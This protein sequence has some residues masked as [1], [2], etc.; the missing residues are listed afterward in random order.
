LE[1]GIEG[2]GRGLRHRGA[3]GRG[4]RLRCA[5]VVFALA[6]SSSGCYRYSRVEL[7]TVPPAADVRLH[8]TW[9]GLEGR[10]DLVDARIVG[11]DAVPIVRGTLLDRDGSSV[12]LGVRVD[13]ANRDYPGTRIEQHVTIPVDAILDAEMRSLRR[14]ET[15]LVVAGGVAAA[16]LLLVHIVGDAI[17]DESR[18]PELQ[19]WDENRMPLPAD[20][21]QQIE[22]RSLLPVGIP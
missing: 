16:A 21:Y 22:G 14:F 10:E 13:D 17:S 9:S 15:G 7:E 2:Q 6:V 18:P 1:R 8:L 12:M 3:S 5:A 4:R 11:T 19:P 20:A